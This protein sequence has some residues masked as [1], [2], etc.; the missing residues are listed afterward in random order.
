MGRGR[1]ELKRIEKTTNRQVTFFKRRNGL[2]KKAFELS[3]LCDAEVALIIFSPTGKLYQFANPDMDRILARY[4]YEVRMAQPETNNQTSRTA[5]FWREEIEDLRK[6]IQTLEARHRHLA[7]EDISLLGIKE[8]QELERQLKIGVER[9]RSRK[10]R[11]ISESINLLK[12][13]KALQNDNARLQRQL[14]VENSISSFWEGRSNACLTFQSSR[15]GQ[16][17]ADP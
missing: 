17:E 8:L 2:L 6:S 3:I 9:I 11:A 12:T 7:G 15:P 10:R 5:Q 4:R 13:R 14:H 1:V 16:D